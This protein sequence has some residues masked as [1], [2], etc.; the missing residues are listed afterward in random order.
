MAFFMTIHNNNAFISFIFY[1]FYT[2][3]CLYIRIANRSPDYT[4]RDLKLFIPIKRQAF[5]IDGHMYLRSS[6]GPLAIIIYF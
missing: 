5:D 6:F 4:F 3:R 2:I 1:S